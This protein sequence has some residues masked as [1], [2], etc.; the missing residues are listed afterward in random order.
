MGY[1]SFCCLIVEERIGW[2]SGRYICMVVLL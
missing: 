1:G 2:G